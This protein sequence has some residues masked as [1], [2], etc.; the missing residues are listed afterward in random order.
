MIPFTLDPLFDPAT[1]FLRGTL[2]SREDTAQLEAL[3]RE[4]LYQAL[5]DEL[6]SNAHYAF[7]EKDARR[8]EDRIRQAVKPV[9][10]AALHH[11][12]ED[13]AKDRRRW[14]PRTGVGRLRRETDQLT[15]LSS[16]SSRNKLRDWLSAGVT[17]AFAQGRHSDDPKSPPRSVADS[18]P[19][20]LWWKALADPAQPVVTRAADMF[21]VVVRDAADDPDGTDASR[22]Y[23]QRLD[24]SLA[25]NDRRR[26]RSRRA[27]ATTVGGVTATGVLSA[28]EIT[29]SVH[30][31]LPAT[32]SVGA[33]S[34]ALVAWLVTRARATPT[35][36]EISELSMAIDG[37]Q[38]WVINAEQ[39]PPG[40]EKHLLDVLQ[41]RL[42]PSIES[43]EV[44]LLR[45]GLGRVGGL[46]EDRAAKQ[47]SYQQAK[48]D[49]A[50]RELH[51][52]VDPQLLAGEP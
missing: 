34:A 4:T 51:R 43:F 33:V 13:A 23:A 39:L 42:L 44:P 45:A 19:W 3:L 49:G 37:I 36:A 35:A 52:L 29:Q 8:D 41:R 25:K 24:D 48:L 11:A 2:R 1:K 7:G 21:E 10:T 18:E 5:R 6:L 20:G 31:L 28:V 15:T 12:N 47:P 9:V 17:A 14:S 40:Q 26:E 16:L 30:S 27:V 22:K 46:L 50:L 38:D 32:A